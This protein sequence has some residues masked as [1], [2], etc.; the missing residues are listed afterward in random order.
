MN[1]LIKCLLAMALST[2][3]IPAFADPPCGP[4]PPGLTN[5][6]AGEGNA[7]D[8][9]GSANGTI[10]GGV[11]FVPGI[12][13]Q[14]FRFDGT[15][16]LIDLGSN[17]GNFGTSDFSIVYWVRTTTSVEQ[18]VM[19]KREPCCCENFVD[20][21]MWSG[22]LGLEMLEGPSGNYGF[23][24]G[25]NYDHMRVNDGQWHLIAE[26]REGT[27]LSIF[28]DNRLDIATVTQ[29]VVNIASAI[30]FIVGWNACIGIGP[31]PFGGGQ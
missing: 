17:V 13:G 6:W 28:V 21:R 8:S 15:S 10:S 19:G 27:T 25:P 24:G 18:G 12:I 7:E 29:G 23:V 9:R 11:S 1:P 14:A 3:F 31:V 30:P 26:I 16:G 5:W 20:I 2:A 22:L 4:P